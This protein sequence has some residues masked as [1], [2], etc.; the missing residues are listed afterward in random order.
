MAS[1]DQKNPLKIHA[2]AGAA[3]EA[4]RFRQAEGLYRQAISAAEASMG[5]SHPHVAKMAISLVDLYE[6]QGRYDEARQLCER[7][8]GQI[9]PAEAAVANDQTLSRLKDLCSRAG[10]LYKAAELYR[11]AMTYRRQVFGDIHG[12]VAACIAG[13]AETYRD[14]GNIAKA[15]SLLLR[16]IS[17]AEEAEDDSIPAALEQR[18]RELRQTVLVAA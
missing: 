14:L 1:L 9:D 18:L 6:D 10:Q 5:G 16:A 4:G 3:I 7:V 13:M 11:E 2:A 17:M 8:I 15:R 12:K